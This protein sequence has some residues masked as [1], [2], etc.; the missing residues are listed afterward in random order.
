MGN[1]LNPNELMDLANNYTKAAKRAAET[2]S[3]HT[4]FQPHR[5]EEIKETY[6]RTWGR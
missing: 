2:A 5:A 1:T 4:L 3:I 6:L